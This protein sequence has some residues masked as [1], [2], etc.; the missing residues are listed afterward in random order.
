MPAATNTVPVTAWMTMPG[1][2]LSNAWLTAPSS[3]PSTAEYNSASGAFTRMV[4]DMNRPNARP[5]SAAVIS[6]GV[7]SRS[8]SVT[9]VMP[10]ASTIVPSIA[11]SRTTTSSKVMDWTD[12]RG[13]TYD[14]SATIL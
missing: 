10:P 7:N 1:C 12:G 5:P 8:G 4:N 13:P 11:A 3:T 6:T 9:Q 2:Q 14:G